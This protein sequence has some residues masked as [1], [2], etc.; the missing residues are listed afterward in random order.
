MQVAPT[1]GGSR[2]WRA[3]FMVLTERTG[4]S[5]IGQS[6]KLN[7]AS[8]GVCHARWQRSTKEHIE[9]NLERKWLVLLHPLST[10][11]STTGARL[12]TEAHKWKPVAPQQIGRQPEMIRPRQKNAVPFEGGKAL[13]RQNHSRLVGST[14]C[15][16]LLPNSGIS[17]TNMRPALFS[18]WM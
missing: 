12:T 7:S 5:G 14:N 18:S 1:W 4:E 6:S 15:K 11:S 10:G 16:Q 9:D 3:E 8:C 2:G 17:R 13:T